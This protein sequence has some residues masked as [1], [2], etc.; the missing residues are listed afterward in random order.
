MKGK[1]ASDFGL[2]SL[3]DEMKSKNAFDFGSLNTKKCG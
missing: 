1:N 3:M 2:R